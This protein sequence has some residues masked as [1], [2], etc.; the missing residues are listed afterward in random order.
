[1]IMIVI[2]RDIVCGVAL[3]GDSGFPLEPWL[4]TPL[5]QATDRSEMAYNNAHCKTRSVIE[6]CFG[7]LKSRF[8]CLDKGGG[9]LLYSAEKTCRLVT[10]V[11]VL[12]NI[13]I[14]HKSSRKT[15]DIYS[16]A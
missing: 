15:K 13:S 3:T 1:M 12:H 9:T 8:P 6:R 7:L 10:A 11:D 2:N 5:A 4:L 14:S 16:L